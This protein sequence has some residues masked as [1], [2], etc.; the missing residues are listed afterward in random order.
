MLEGVRI[1]Y[2]AM[3]EEASESNTSVPGSEGHTDAV[4][5]GLAALCVSVVVVR[6]FGV[7]SK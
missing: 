2:D 1:G 5:L 4:H 6:H 3:D 7:S